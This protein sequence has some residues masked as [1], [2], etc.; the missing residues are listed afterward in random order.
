V[1]ITSLGFQI[2]WN[3]K[4]FTHV[5]SLELSKDFLEAIV[6]DDNLLKYI[7]A[8]SAIYQGIR[9]T[10]ELVDNSYNDVKTPISSATLNGMVVL[11]LVELKVKQADKCDANTC[12]EN[13]ANVIIDIRPLLITQAQ[14]DVIIANQSG[15][16]YFQL[17]GDPVYVPRFDIPKTVLTTKNDIMSAF[18]KLVDAGHIKTIDDALKALFTNA[19]TVLGYLSGFNVLNTNPIDPIIASQKS[20][21]NVQYVYNWLLDI[22][23]AHNEILSIGTVY[24]KNVVADNFPLHVLAGPTDAV[25]V[26]P[27]TA[28]VIFR[29]RHWQRPKLIILIDWKGFSND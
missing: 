24:N 19:N 29:H 13:G 14:A 1:A 27:N 16:A 18:Q 12:D 23:Q 4:T 8:K 22:V 17:A 26:R 15:Q 25:S 2:Q 21:N 6:D 7:H 11:I 9:E 10:N 28:P 20:T 3:E 5:R